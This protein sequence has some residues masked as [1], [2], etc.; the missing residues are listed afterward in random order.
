MSYAQN[1]HPLA[2]LSEHATD[3]FGDTA[4]NADVDFVK[5]QGRSAGGLGGNHL[6]RQA[7]ARE[8]TP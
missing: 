3:H 7:D 4:A 2:Q 8:F 6:N 5:H 1:L